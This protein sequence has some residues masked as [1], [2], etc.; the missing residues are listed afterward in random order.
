[1]EKVIKRLTASSTWAAS[2]DMTPIDFPKEGLITEVKI[3][4]NITATLTATA[5][6][7]FWRRVLQNIKIQ[8]DG[9]RSYLG[10]SGEG[11]SRMLALW[12]EIVL[13]VPTL[14]S[15]GAD[16]ALAGV[17]VG[18]TNFI[19]ELIFHPGSNPKDPFDLSACIPARALSTLQAALTTAAAAVTDPNG[20]ITAGTF[21]YEINEVMGVPVQPGMMT[22]LGSTLSYAHT[23]N[24]SDNGYDIDVP[25]GAFLRSIVML[26]QDATATTPYRKDDE[27][28]GIKLKRPKA[29]DYLF[30]QSIYEAKQTMMSR[31]GCRG[32]AG[33]VTPIG[34]IA[35]IRPA[36]TSVIDNI[37]A[38]FVV[39]DLRPYGHP[40]YGLD[41]RNYQTG[42]FKLG[43]T[44]ANYAAG[45]DTIIYWDQLMPVSNDLVG[46]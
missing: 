44:I 9:G 31:Y 21:N 37:P 1:M 34:A 41:L 11:M 33:D 42:D 40:L 15:N 14:H 22:P 16:I 29:G 38:G 32:I 46:R 26:I 6:G 4:A 2:T 5:V 30:E 13:G 39:I 45:D 19:T 8:G 7:E 35:T 18:S 10:M 28:T 23:A 43:L 20:A 27:V 12:N 3:R 24:Y 17:D 25:A 36:P